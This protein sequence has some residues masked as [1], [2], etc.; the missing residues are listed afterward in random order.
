[1]YCYKVFKTQSSYTTGPLT[2]D[3]LF[4][5]DALEVS[6]AF[7]VIAHLMEKFLMG[8]S[9]DCGLILDEFT[10]NRHRFLDKLGSMEQI[11]NY[12]CEHLL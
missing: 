11:V 9:L 12:V 6:H 1:M 7:L 2:A 10:L 4:R 8:L 5:A 3:P